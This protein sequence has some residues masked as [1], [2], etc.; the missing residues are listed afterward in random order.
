MLIS[1]LFDILH[2]ELYGPLFLFKYM[3]KLYIF[4]FHLLYVCMTGIEI[5]EISLGFGFMG[6][7]LDLLQAERLLEIEGL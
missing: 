3:C 6:L 4:L 5:L 2:I 7:G 1:L